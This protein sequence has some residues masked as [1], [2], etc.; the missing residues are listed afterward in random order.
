MTDDTA[1]LRALAAAFPVP[2]IRLDDEPPTYTP[3]GGDASDEPPPTWRAR[4]DL[5][6]PD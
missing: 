2:P 4:A 5:A 6:P 3:S 1:R